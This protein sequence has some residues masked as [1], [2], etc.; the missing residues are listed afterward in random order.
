MDYFNKS[1]PFAF[2]KF[3]KAES[4]QKAVDQ[5]MAINIMLQNMNLKIILS[6]HEKVTNFTTQTVSLEAQ[7][8][9]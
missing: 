9:G 7:H 1:P 5:H 2:I 4:A 3:R 6:D 8:S